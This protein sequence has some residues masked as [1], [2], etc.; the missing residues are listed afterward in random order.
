MPITST[1]NSYP[2]EYI[3]AMLLSAP[4]ARSRIKLIAGLCTVDKNFPIHLWDQLLPQAEIT[5]NLLR[6]SPINPKSSAWA[7]AHGTFDFNRTPLGPPGRRV[8]AHA[9]PDKRKTWPPHGLDG[10]YAGPTL[11]SYRCYKIWIWETRALR[12]IDTLTWFP[13]KVKLPNSSSTDII[14]SCLQDIL[15]ALNNPSPKSPLAPRTDTQTQALHDL[16]A[17]LGSVSPTTPALI[18]TP[19]T[20]AVPTT[21]TSAPLRVRFVP[22][23]PVQ[24]SDQPLRVATLDTVPT[25]TLPGLMI[26]EFLEEQYKTEHSHLS[27][28]PFGFEGCVPLQLPSPSL[29]VLPTVGGTRRYI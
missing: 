2:Q 25:P 22:T 26:D 21:K 9:K 5:L 28:I 13:S 4:Y 24:T 7:Q 1:S 10:W 11:H 6:G 16:M 17:L 19:P 18:V 20:A 29:R 8:L 12:I 15:H 14:L 3:S 23:E 27:P